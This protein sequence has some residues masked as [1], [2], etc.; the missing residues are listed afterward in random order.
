MTLSKLMQAMDCL[1]KTKAIPARDMSPAM[2]RFLRSCARMVSKQYPGLSGYYDPE[3][4]ACER[5]DLDKHL[6]RP[7]F[8]SR[9]IPQSDELASRIIARM[10]GPTM[11][12]MLE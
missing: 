11:D 5:I 8:Y 6:C 10:K 12:W 9:T 3:A 7:A 1:Q 2:F 4:P